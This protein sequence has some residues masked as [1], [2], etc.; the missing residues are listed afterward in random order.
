MPG[1]PRD[2]RSWRKIAVRGELGDALCENKRGIADIGL[3][4]CRVALERDVNATQLLVHMIRAERDMQ[5][6]YVAQALGAGEQL[7]QR[8]PK[9]PVGVAH[10]LFLRGGNDEAHGDKG[11]AVA[12][13]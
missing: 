11:S 1:A 5:V 7:M 8:N 13:A 6:R 3:M 2:K 12:F 9:M 4:P 10:L